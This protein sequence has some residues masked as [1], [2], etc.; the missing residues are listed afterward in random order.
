MWKVLKQLHVALNNNFPSF[1]L[2]R[3]Q[4]Q[5]FE[6]LLQ[7][8]DVLRILPTGFGKSLVF[9]PLPDFLPVKSRQ[10]I[11]IVVGPL[12]SIIE[13]QISALKLIGI[14]ADILPI[15]IKIHHFTIQIVCSSVRK[16]ARANKLLYQIFYMILLY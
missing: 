16:I 9:Q 7:G 10:N 1:C 13:D 5:C 11:V 14:P 12:T 3:K 6:Y 8:F 15:I 4:V 2:K